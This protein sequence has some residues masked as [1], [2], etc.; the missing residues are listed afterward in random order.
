MGQSFTGKFYCSQNLQLCKVVRIEK[1]TAIAD[2]MCLY[3]YI[4]GLLLVT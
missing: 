1:N 2:V 3:G 4:E